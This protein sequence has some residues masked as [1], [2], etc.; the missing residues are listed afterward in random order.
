[1]TKPIGPI[2]NLD[3]RYCF[4]LEKEEMFR[5][6]GRS[7]RSSWQM[8]PQLLEQYIQQYIE[9]QNVPEIHFAWQGGEPTLLGIS[10]FQKAVELQ[11]KYAN[12][13][14]IHNALQTNGTLLTPEWCDFLAQNRFLIGL[15]L[16]GPEYLHNMYRVDKAQQ[17]TFDRVMT[18]LQL[19]KEFQV[20]FNT[21]TVVHR[22]NARH[23]EE[24]YSFLKEC[25]S[26]FL[27]FIPLVERRAHSPLP[28]PDGPLQIQFAPPPHKERNLEAVTEWSVLPEDYGDFLITVFN[29]WVQ[30]DVGEIYVQLFESALGTWLGEGA[31]L[32]VF[33]PE[34]GTALAL[35]HNGDVY[36]CDHYVYPKY[37]LGNL[38]HIPLA[39]MAHSPQQRS[40]GREKQTMLPRFCRECPVLFACQGECPKHRFTQTPQGEWG[41]NYLCA[42]YKK[43]FTHIDP[44]MKRMAALLRSGRSPAEIMHE[45]TH[46]RP[47][48]STGRNDPCPCGSGQK[49]KKCCLLN[50]PKQ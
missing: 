17:N 49:Y 12:G 35:E 23:P 42:A 31:S 24:I 10:F 15:S 26:R 29:R 47:A 27:Q 41:L 6:E 3:C 30:S 32:C 34:C 20:E 33:R 22:H 9:G 5:Q 28:S 21:L 13:K 37:R 8:S 38:M 11:H 46:M 50:S 14:I 36:S 19:M 18:G 1:M 45:H 4:Y 7:P 2:C 39:E 40:F 43:F 48:A 44:F 25:G 16:D